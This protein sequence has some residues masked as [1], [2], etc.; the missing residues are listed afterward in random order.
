MLKNLFILIAACMM[1]SCSQSNANN[2]DMT[3]EKT[4]PETVTRQGDAIVDIKTT[5]G[6]IKIRLFGD[7]PRHRDNFLKLVNEGFYDG[8]LFHRVI[9]DFMIQTGD[10]KSK[11][12][13]PGEMLG[14]GDP[15]Y[16][17]EAEIEYPRHYHVR[18]ALAAART[19]DEMNPERR[20]SGSQF[21]IVTGQSYND[22][23]LTQMERSM[24]QQQKQTIFNQKAAANRDKIMDLRRNRDQAGLMALQEQLIAE[25]EAE[26]KANPVT[27]PADVRKAYIE[28]GGAPHLDGAYTVFG[29][30]I[31]GMDVVEKIETAET[32]RADRPKEDIRIISMSVEK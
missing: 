20:S 30:V 16:T 9:K 7:T 23:T 27:I 15:G 25:T 28:K 17:V 4:A 19:G 13:A 5:A 18:G 14:M 11:N 1:F 10:P 26:A 31:S 8:V 6:D 2:K 3:T 21:Y 24:Q 29:E 12:A 32:G 22:S